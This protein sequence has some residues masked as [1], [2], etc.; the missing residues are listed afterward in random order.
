LPACVKSGTS[1]DI[2]GTVSY[3][4]NISGPLYVVIDNATSTGGDHVGGTYVD[5][6]GS[7]PWKYVVRGLPQS[8]GSMAVTAYLDAIGVQVANSAADPM[9]STPFTLSGTSIS[10]VDV[11]LTDPTPVVPAA[12]GIQTVFR[13][14]TRMGVLFRP[15]QD[16]NGLEYA[17]K[18]A[19]YW[20]TSPNPGPS[21]YLGALTV[22]PGRNFAAMNGFTPG[23]IYYF[24][25][26]AISAAGESPVSPIAFAV[27]GTPSVGSTISGTVSFPGIPVSS[28][29]ALYVIAY[30]GQG[31]L[32][33]QVIDSPSSV[34]SFTISGVPDGFYRQLAFL[35]L[36]GDGRLAPTEPH[37]PFDSAPGVV[38]NGGN[39]TG[40]SLVISSAAAIARVSTDH[41]VGTGGDGY[42]VQF[43]IQ[44]NTKVPVSA[45]LCSGPN[46]VTP[47]DMTV[48][49]YNDGAVTQRWD[50]GN[51][52]PA[53][54]DQYELIVTYSDGKMESFTVS[55]TGVL[56]DAP[57][58]LAPGATTTSQTPTFAWTLPGS[59]PASYYQTVSVWKNQ[60][61]YWEDFSI[62]P[63]TTSIIYNSDGS[64][65]PPTLGLGTY[66]WS[67]SV[68]DTN[69]NRVSRDD[70]FA[71]VAP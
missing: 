59:L 8:S 9:G 18:Y 5:T 54:G 32:R 69:G 42:S 44:G 25:V 27:A 22:P 64:A 7:P 6:T 61:R 31:A 2:S 34:Q 20:H 37:T 35:D 46:V 23:T 57:T 16:A 29:T 53:K 4:G 10:N 62:P 3:A 55:V 66:S 19:I 50:F 39:V 11:A 1:I 17:E 70:S 12:P 45:V 24:G 67:I 40:Q 56:P 68:Q 26:T 65:S 15:P 63:G 30:S 52:P 33:A 13:T 60:S 36:D 51:T 41:F 14:G 47:S 21:N 49:R 43:D 58:I 48:G 38:V 28:T 71:V